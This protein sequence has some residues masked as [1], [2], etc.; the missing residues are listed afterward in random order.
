MGY[1]HYWHRDEIE[2]PVPLWDQILVRLTPLIEENATRLG[3]RDI[4]ID[5]DMVFFNGQCETFVVTRVFHGSIFN[6]VCFDFCKTRQE[7]YDPL[8]IA[9]LLIIT[10]VL[11]DSTVGFG[12]GSDGEFPHD[13]LSGIELAGMTRETAPPPEELD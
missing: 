13:H 1:T 5:D 6:G 7:A 11:K 2:I 9:C 4:Q 3:I 10:D 12:W 8:V